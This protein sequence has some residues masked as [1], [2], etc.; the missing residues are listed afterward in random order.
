VRLDAQGPYAR[1]YCELDRTGR[2]PH[3][4]FTLSDADVLKAAKE[5]GITLRKSPKSASVEDAARIFERI[6]GKKEEISDKDFVEKATSD[7]DYDQVQAKE[8]L[9]MLYGDYRIVITRERL[10]TYY[11]RKASS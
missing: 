10:G 8:M 5:R 7:T 4:G 11:F 1:L 3:V 9:R 2:C 6:I